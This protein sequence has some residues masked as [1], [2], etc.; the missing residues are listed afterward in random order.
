MDSE[1]LP[2]AE[3]AALD[4]SAVQDVSMHDP[5]FE[6]AITEDLALALLKNRDLS[7]DAVEQLA[8]NSGVTKSR[9]VRLA[10]AAHPRAAR[11]VCLRL[12]R[13]FYTFDLMRFALLPGVAADI[14]HA[15]DELL[16]SRIASVTLGERI[17]LARRA[18]KTITAA[19]LLDKEAPVWQAAVESPR[20]TEAAV[21]RALRRP[22]ATP[23]LVEAICHH[24]RWS[25][26]HEIRIALLRNPHTQLARALEFAHALPPAQLR[27]A[28]HGSQISERLKIYLRKS[29]EQKNSLG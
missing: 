13:D 1:K 17:S 24:P 22:S 5:A 7:S 10:I 3:A 21:V 4:A 16:L 28:L 8:K 26:R 23:A 29:F 2:H 14:K 9:R 20:L 19:L 25:P 27:D 15:A 18:S 6:P 12:I 11:H